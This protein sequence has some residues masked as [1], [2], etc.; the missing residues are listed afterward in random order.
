MSAPWSPPPST[1]PP[2]SKAPWIIGGAC[3]TLLALAL[4]VATVLGAVWF[5]ALRE[6]PMDVVTRYLTAWEAEDCE[7]YEE[8]T[9][10]PFRGEDYTCEQWQETVRYWPENDYSFEHELAEGDLRGDRAT[11]RVTETL[12]HPDVT[13]RQV[14]DVVLTK[15]NGSWLIHTTRVV[16]ELERI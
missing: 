9:T 1:P 3:C 6:T 10:E 12:I 7:T 2:R 5:L 14:Y 8:V 4:V 11:V 16:E 15:Q 13:E